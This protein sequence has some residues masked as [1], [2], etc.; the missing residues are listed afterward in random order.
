M[1][2]ILGSPVMS[3]MVSSIIG[4]M[5]VLGKQRMADQQANMELLSAAPALLADWP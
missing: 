2:E 3:G 4:A 5:V 1:M